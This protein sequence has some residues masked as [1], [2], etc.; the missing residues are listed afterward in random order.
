ML[1]PFIARAL[2]ALCAACAECAP[3]KLTLRCCGASCSLQRSS[4]ALKRQ[5][6]ITVNKH[7]THN[8]THQIHI[9]FY[10]TAKLKLS[11]SYVQTLCVLGLVLSSYAVYVEHRISAQSENGEDNEFTAICDIAAMGASCRYA[12]YIIFIYERMIMI[13]GWISQIILKIKCLIL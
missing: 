1:L 2:S 10:M 7:L 3:I 12:G 6:Q 5:T 4:A 9:P 8:Y 11:S 13:I